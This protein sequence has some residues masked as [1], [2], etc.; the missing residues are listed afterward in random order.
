MLKRLTI[1]FLCNL[2]GFCVLAKDNNIIDVGKIQ[3]YEAIPKKLLYF[4]DYSQ[5]YTI[6]NV[7]GDLFVPSADRPPFNPKHLDANYFIKLTLINTGSQDSFLLYAGKAQDYSMYVWDSIAGK[8]I[9][10]NNDIGK[11]SPGLFTRVPYKQIVIKNGEQKTFYIKANIHF[12]NWYLFDPVI[13]RATD[14]AYFS[15]AHLLQP[16]R[17]YMS[18]TIFFLG[19]MFCMFAYT[20]TLF[21]RK[22]LWEYFYYSAALFAFMVYFGLRLMNVFYFGELYYSFYDLR[23]QGLQLS[24]HILILLFII[25]FLNTKKMMPV[26]HKQAKTIIYLQVIFLIVNLPLTYTNKYN[27]AANIAFDVMRIFVLLY[28]IYIA[29]Y[30]LIKNTQKEARYLGIGSLLSIL[31]A[32]VALYVDRWANFDDLL[33]RYSGISVLIFMAGVMLQMTLFLLALSYRRRMQEAERVRAVE[34]LQLE[35]DR[36]ELEKYRAIIDARDSERTRISQEIHDD[37]GS[38]LTSIRLLS[39]ITKAKNKTGDNKELEKISSTSNILI[40]KMNEIIWTLNSRNDT[41]LNLIGYLRHQIVE[42]FEPLNITLEINIPDTLN[43]M[44]VSG[45]IRRNIIL[46]VKEALHN[47]VKH[48]QASV[49]KVDFYFNEVFTISIQDNG[50]GFSYVNTNGHTNGLRNMKERLISIGGSCNITSDEG[51]KILIKIPLNMYPV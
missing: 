27:Y 5:S 16:S 24:G 20:I 8:K 22:P 51:T 41:L 40:D 36:N 31:M 45:K 50:I 30:L 35:N 46:A 15:Y 29:I 48:S 25:W 14:D 3:H 6:D 43:D 9:L 1:V 12:Y 28:S 33:L 49:V 11:F 23:Y 2:L 42:F 34:Q 39:E 21:I 37:I 17:I 38:G 47:I 4:I 7:T 13:L 18:T 26:F 10:L 32:C 44:P 19:I